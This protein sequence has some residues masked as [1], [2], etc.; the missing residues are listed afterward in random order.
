PVAALP[1]VAVDHV[2][3]LVVRRDGDAVGTVDLLL[4]QHPPGL[5]PL[6]DAVDAFDVHLQVGAVGAVARVGEPDAP[7]AIDAAVVWAVVALAVVAVGQHLD[8]AGL[9]VRAHDAAAARALLAAFAADEPALG[10]EAVAVG[11][12][13]V[14]AE[15][16]HRPLGVHLQD[17]VAGDVA[18]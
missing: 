6:V 4:R 5:A 11:A 2:E 12:A 16:G 10:V 18:E 14:G 9:H 1:G 3:G 13:A 8:L 17:A 15:G 7:L